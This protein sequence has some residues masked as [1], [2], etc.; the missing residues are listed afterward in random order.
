M[1]EKYLLKF[2]AYSKIPLLCCV[3]LSFVILPF[4]S[5]V[6]FLESSPEANLIDGK[7][8][9]ESA[10]CE[11][12]EEIF[13]EDET[14]IHNP[15]SF[16]IL[17]YDR[18][19]FELISRNAAAQGEDL[20]FGAAGAEFEADDIPVP[21]DMTF[22]QD[23]SVFYITANSLSFRELP[24]VE[25]DIIK[26]YYF[27][28]RLLRTGIGDGWF[29]VEDDSGNTG[30]VMSGYFSETKPTPSPTPTPVP[31]RPPVRANTLGESIAKEAQ[32]YLGVRYA[33][34]ANDPNRAF[35]C[36]GLTWYVFNRYGIKTPRASSAY[37]NAGIII[38]YS[39][40]APGDVIS[41]SNPWTSR[42]IDHVGIY[43]GDGKMVHATISYGVVIHS[44]AQYR[45][46]GYRMV[47]VH[48]FL[49]E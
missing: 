1:K 48:R 19:A 37:A 41:W 42:R 7:D 18:E 32:K 24:T 49:K 11:Y 47:S 39:Q 4:T 22:E 13:V 6:V 5:M 14:R 36:T 38:P 9:V 28:D 30:Y 34:G 12:Y 29:R 23:D 25:A 16:E 21:P 2:I 20:F 27:G 3:F 45:G 44:V 43:I 8:S 35:D 10:T 26:R 40:I 33:W 17:D 15:D 31:T 46:W